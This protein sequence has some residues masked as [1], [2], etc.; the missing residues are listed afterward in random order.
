MNG[1]GVLEP[2]SNGCLQDED[3]S[4]GP[5]GVGYDIPMLDIGSHCDALSCLSPFI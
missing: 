2:K 5:G 3:S 4:S 1:V